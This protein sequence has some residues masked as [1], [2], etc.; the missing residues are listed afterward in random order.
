V[1][2]VEQVIHKLAERTW[3]VA[4]VRVSPNHSPRITRNAREPLVKLT[5]HVAPLIT[6]SKDNASGM[7]WKI[8][9]RDLHFLGFSK[10]GPSGA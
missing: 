3:L 5:E 6:I 4:G 1:L 10:S 9:F 2:D 7:S 8:H